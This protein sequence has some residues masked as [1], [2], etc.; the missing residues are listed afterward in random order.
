MAQRFSQFTSLNTFQD[1]PIYNE[2]VLNCCCSV[3]CYCDYVN[4]CCYN[5]PTICYQGCQIWHGNDDIAATSAFGT[6][7]V[8]YQ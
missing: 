4:N 7:V 8:K 5:C 2:M 1:K 3:S 6:A